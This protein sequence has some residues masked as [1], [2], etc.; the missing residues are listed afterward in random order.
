MGFRPARLAGHRAKLNKSA[1][2]AE[3]HSDNRRKRLTRGEVAQILGTRKCECARGFPHQMET[4]MKALLVSSALGLG[5][6]LTSA[7]WAQVPDGATASCKDGTYYTGTTH[8]GACRGHKGV[9]KWLDGGAAA[10]SEKAA[11]EPA[12]KP[13]KAKKSKKAEKAEAAAPAAAPVSAAPAGAT[14]SCKDGTFYTGTTHKGACRGHKGVKEWL[15][16]GAAA[17]APAAKSAPAAAPAP[18]VAPAAPATPAAAPAA[19]AATSRRTPPT[20]ASQIAQKPGG[21]P[22]LVWV[23]AGTKV[24]HCQGDE[25]YGKTKEGSYMSEAAAKA[26][27]NHGARGKDCSQ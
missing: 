9:D 13:A 7:A 8:K 22:G 6:L 17:A 20:P 27:G 14:A 15:D 24:Y 16:G 1:K 18:T 21:G 25:W 3:R 10:A 2:T 12:A 11:P 26:A 19:K 23:N 4:A 5:V